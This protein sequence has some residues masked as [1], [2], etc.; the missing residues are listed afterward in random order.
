MNSFIFV[1]F[2]SLVNDFYKVILEDLEFVMK[3]FFII[4]EVKG[5]VICVV[6][7]YLYVKVCFIFFI[8]IDGL[9][10]IIVLMDSE[11]KIYLEKV[12][13]VVDYLI[14]NVGLLGVKFYD[15]VE[16]VFDENNNKNNEEVFFIVCYFIIMVYNFCG[17]YFNCV[18]KY[19]E[20]YNNNILGIYFL[21][22]IF[23]YVM[24]I[25]GYEVFKLVKGNCYMEFSKYMFD[26]Y[27]EKDGCYKVFFKDI[28]YVNN[29]MNSI[30]NGYMWNE[31]DV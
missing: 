17:N 16:V 30:K 14:Q 29:V 19:F 18:W 11:S 21:G 31:V 24:N 15:D 8:Y 20:V 13:V 10:N 7:Y 5:Y 25:N 27:G 6:V 28:Y 2:C 22:M 1:F 4:Q 9:G 26:L 12:K 23:S 3:N